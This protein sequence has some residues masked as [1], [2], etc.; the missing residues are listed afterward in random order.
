MGR[1]RL[2]GKFSDWTNDKRALDTRLDLP[3]WRVHDLRRSCAT[4]MANRLGIPP[5]IVDL[6]LGHVGHRTGV[7]GVYIRS[8]YSVEVKSAM[9]RW[10]D[11]IASLITGGERKVLAYKPAFSATL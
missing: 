1:D 5:Y 3:A 8:E 10:S 2:F 11:H 6:A 7:T 9:L 4:G